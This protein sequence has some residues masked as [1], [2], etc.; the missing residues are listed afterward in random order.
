LSTSTPRG[1]AE[2]KV[3]NG[4]KA[5]LLRKTARGMATAS[6][7]LIG[8]WVKDKDGELFYTTVT[9]A[10]GTYRRIYQDLKRSA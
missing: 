2:G 1:A 9:H 5:K 3:M 4:R 6:P 7:K 8:G 10:Q